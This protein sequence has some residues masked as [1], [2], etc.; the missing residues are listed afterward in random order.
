[1]WRWIV[2]IVAAL[3]VGLMSG[4]AMGRHHSEHK[5]KHFQRGEYGCKSENRENEH[6]CQNCGREMEDDDDDDFTDRD[7]REEERPIIVNMH[8]MGPC[9]AGGQNFGPG[10][11]RPSPMD[12]MM[13]RRE[14]DR[15][16][17]PQPDREMEKYREMERMRQQEWDKRQEMENRRWDEG[18]GKEKKEMQ[19]SQKK[20][21][22]VKV[23]PKPSQKKNTDKKID[24][25][26]G[27]NS[28]KP[29][30]DDDFD[31]NW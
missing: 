23:N 14:M 27:N 22:K 30:D 5:Y 18:I 31:W 25:K 15:R 6:R 24:K 26:P 9:C 7:K 4:A 12:E 2:G 13:Q 11:G 17:E 3:I 28:D 8:C 29:K 10:P 19:P 1:M 16:F 21:S 20:D